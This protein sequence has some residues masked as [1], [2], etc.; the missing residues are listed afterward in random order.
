ML[1][2]NFSLYTVVYAT[3][4]TFSISITSFQHKSLQHLTNQIFCIYFICVC[5]KGVMF[6]SCFIVMNNNNYIFFIL[7]KFS[8]LKYL[9]KILIAFV[10]ILRE[11]LYFLWSQKI[12][13]HRGSYM[14]IHV[15]IWNKCWRE[16]G[17]LSCTKTLKE[18]YFYK[19]II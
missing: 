3:K 11:H 5:F 4:F 10:F 1:Y 17:K 13:L 6:K 14:H 2:K 15:D 12:F 16:I 7:N 19:K 18:I 8:K 9:R